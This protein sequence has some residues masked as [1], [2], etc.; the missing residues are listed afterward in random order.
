MKEKITFRE[1]SKESVILRLDHAIEWM[2]EKY[3]HI[4]KGKKKLF[5]NDR[6]LLELLKIKYG[7]KWEDGLSKLLI[8]RRDSTCL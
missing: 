3:C 1:E 7:V 4:P 8:K 5:T 2:N 6:I